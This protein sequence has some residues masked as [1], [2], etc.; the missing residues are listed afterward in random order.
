MGAHES[1]R[2]VRLIQ[3]S[4]IS[5]NVILAHNHYQ[6][7][8]RMKCH[9]CQ[10]NIPFT[11]FSYESKLFERVM[12][13]PGVMNF[14]RSQNEVDLILPRV[15]GKIAA[16]DTGRKQKLEAFA[17]SVKWEEQG[18]YVKHTEK[19]NRIS[20]ASMLM[21]EVD[22][23]RSQLSDN[24]WEILSNLT[25]TGSSESRNVSSI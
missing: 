13:T 18:C 1:S 10:L 15:V 7:A 5:S 12:D 17:E 3:F 4:T 23:D 8:N 25:Q 2:N 14:C 21:K 9:Y 16:T 11:P 6:Q 19:K 20:Q 24:E 22:H